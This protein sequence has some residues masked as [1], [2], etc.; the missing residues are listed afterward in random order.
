M[1]SR[2]TAL[3]SLA[4]A[5]LAPISFTAPGAETYPSRPVRI[6]VPYA[7]GT[8]TDSTS[9]LLAEG[10]AKTWNVPVTV[11]NIAAASGIVGTSTVAKLPGDGYSLVM[12]AANHVINPH[13][14]RDLPFDPLRDFTPICMVA[15]TQLAIVVNAQSDIVDLKGLIAAARSNPGR[16]NYGSAGN[17]SVG[18]LVMEQIKQASNTSIVHIPYRGQN[19]ALTDLAGGQVDVAVPALAAVEP[20]LRSGRLRAIAV[21]GTQRMRLFPDIPTIEEQI[22]TPIEGLAWWGLLGPKGIPADIVELIGSAVREQL[23][24]PAMLEQM[25]TLSAEVLAN[26]AQ[27]MEDMMRADLAKV[28]QVVT[29]ANIKMD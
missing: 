25:R 11:E 10:L 7:V 28:G 6:I 20:L 22:G 19:Q 4:A 16:L 2:R 17:G 9:R 29:A 26:S 18:Q 24:V 27:E 15:Q 1:I 8:A 14:Y 21:T 23:R 13:L 5:T 12:V 3:K